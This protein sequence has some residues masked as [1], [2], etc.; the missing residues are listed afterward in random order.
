MPELTCSCGLDREKVKSCTLLCWQEAV[1]VVQP[2]LL[3]GLIR[4]FTPNSHVTETDAYLYAMGV[5]LCAIVI[6]IAHHPYFFGVT[7]MGM[8][9]RVACCSLMYKKVG[10]RVGSGP[11]LISLMVSVDVKHHVYLPWLEGMGGG[12]GGLYWMY[13]WG[14][15]GGGMMYKKK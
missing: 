6:A 13:R 9:M 15:G 3:G 12:G 10:E 11:S 14:G 5:S 2:L 8:Q 4:F 1:R 7:R